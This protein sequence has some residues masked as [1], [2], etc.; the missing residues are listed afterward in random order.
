M[1]RDTK[2]SSRRRMIKM[3]GEIQSFNRRFRDPYRYVLEEISILRILM[4]E[5][6]AKLQ[7]IICKKS[8][9]D[10]IDTYER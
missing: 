2:D 9:K 8:A 3:S 1:E 5:L 6:V 4:S 10:C 7:N